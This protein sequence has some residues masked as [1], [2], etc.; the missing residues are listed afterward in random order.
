[1]DLLEEKWDEIKRRVILPLWNGKFKKM[2]EDAKMDYNDFESLVGIELAKAIKIF[3]PEKSSLCTFATRVITQKAYTELRDCTK[4]DK[5]MALHTS[6]SLDAPCKDSEISLEAIICGD[7]DNKDESNI[8]GIKRYMK[9]L[10]WCQM[11]IL[12][13]R[14]IGLKK[15]DILN[16]MDMTSAEYEDNLKKI[17]S[18][19]KISRLRNGVI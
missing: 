16:I 3:N 5:K 11:E 7:S 17:Q 2:Y 13:L 6:L 1:M 12:L 9:L 4:R 15:E 19:R 18:G 10:S 14:Y 8:L